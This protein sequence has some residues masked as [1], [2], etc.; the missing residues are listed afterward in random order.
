M[1]QIFQMMDHSEQLSQ[2]VNATSLTGKLLNMCAETMELEGAVTKSFWD[3]SYN[4]L[5]PITTRS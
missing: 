2:H 3:L 4:Y 5:N 1:I